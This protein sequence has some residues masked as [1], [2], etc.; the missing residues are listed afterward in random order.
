MPIIVDWKP[1][2]MQVVHTNQEPPGSQVLSTRWRV[3][4]NNV[5]PSHVSQETRDIVCAL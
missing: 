3:D 4:R 1:R 2:R 5:K